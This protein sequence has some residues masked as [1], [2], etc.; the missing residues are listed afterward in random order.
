MT[1]QV[2]ICSVFALE[3]AGAG[4]ISRRAEAVMRELLQL[5][6]ADNVL[7]AAVSADITRREVT[8]E[9]IGCGPDQMQ[10]LLNGISAMRAAI[11]AAGGATLGWLS[12]RASAWTIV[13][14]ESRLLAPLRA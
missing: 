8:I 11:H 14:Q 6:D 5:E 7:D 13:R 2:E 3:H 1:H 4:D 10:A 9:L 12:D